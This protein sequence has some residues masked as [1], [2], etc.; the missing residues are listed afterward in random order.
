MYDTIMGS[1]SW[2]IKRNEYMCESAPRAVY[3]LGAYGLPLSGGGFTSV[4]LVGTPKSM[5][6]VTVCKARPGSMCIRSIK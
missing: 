3:E 2:V 5:A 4:T 1:T 6:K